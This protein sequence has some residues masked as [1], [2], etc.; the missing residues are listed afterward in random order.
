MSVTP[1]PID[2]TDSQDGTSDLVNDQSVKS[3]DG[4]SLP[5]KQP[6]TSSDP[7]LQVTLLPNGFK[8][9]L[10]PSSDS[11]EVFLPY[12]AGVNR[13]DGLL[14][15]MD[16]GYIPPVLLDFL[17]AKYPNKLDSYARQVDV[18]IKDLR[19]FNGSNCKNS[20]SN[21]RL[22]NECDAPSRIITLYPCNSTVI[23]LVRH[24]LIT[25]SQ[26]NLQNAY[27]EEVNTSSETTATITGNSSIYGLSSNNKMFKRLNSKISASSN[28]SS[29]SNQNKKDGN[30]NR[31]NAASSSSNANDED[32]FL[33]PS[34]E[35]FIESAV[36]LNTVPPLVLDPSPVVHLVER[37]LISVKSSVVSD[38]PA[39]CSKSRLLKKLRASKWQAS[40]TSTAFNVTAPSLSLASFLQEKSTKRS[41]CASRAT[42]KLPTFSIDDSTFPTSNNGSTDYIK[43]VIEDVTRISSHRIPPAAL[44]ANRNG[45]I[46]GSSLV[47]VEEYTMESEASSN[48]NLVSAGTGFQAMRPH[49]SGGGSTCISIFH[50]PVDDMFFGQLFI[51][52]SPVSTSSSR[53]CLFKLG[54]RDAA[55]RY[56][57][58]FKEILTEN[59]RKAV[60]ITRTGQQHLSS[61]PQPHQQSQ[62][63]FNQLSQQQQQQQQQQHYQQ[64]QHLQQ[65]QQFNQVAHQQAQPQFNTVAHQAQ[66]QHPQ[67]QQPQIHIH[68]QVT[69]TP[70]HLQQSHFA[71]QQQSQQQQQQH[72]Q[73]Q[74]LHQQQITLPLSSQVAPTHMQIHNA[75]TSSTATSTTQQILQPQVVT[76]SNVQVISANQGTKVLLP[77]VKTIQL[78]GN[79]IQMLP[80]P[81]QHHQPG[82]QPAIHTNQAQGQ[83][84]Q[85]T[86][87]QE[88]QLTQINAQQLRQIQGTHSFLVLPPP[89]SGPSQVNQSPSQ[90]FGSVQV[91]LWPQ[92][93]Q[94]QQQQQ[95]LQAI[96]AAVN[97]N[98]PNVSQAT[99]QLTQTHSNSANSSGQQPQQ[100]PQLIQIQPQTVAVASQAT[101]ATAVPAGNATAAAAV[102]GLVSPVSTVTNATES[103]NSVNS[104]G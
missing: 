61:H 17:A 27:D 69:Q 13:E 35:Q 66:P 25:L 85:A 33:D 11:P 81:S 5:S 53:S 31:K 14:E 101:A 42:K 91:I 2:Q 6:K 87:R 72:Q 94:Q 23:K 37:K 75:S 7:I 50:S 96:T 77:S 83:M 1:E 3:S 15:F 4:P 30:N 98:Q 46:E 58:Q 74:Q 100:L 22:T 47:K 62:Q 40:P 64:Q 59:G 68:Q 102:L 32:E 71:P 90:P 93:F 67:Q 52:R 45:S 63:Q 84:V 12:E 36:I 16:A 92:Q 73:Q 21:D 10:T 44:N 49:S 54:T 89:S 28:N 48:S 19:E 86:N 56:L 8:L 26:V 29:S 99:I 65:Q 97:A 39:A 103:T 79:Q 38:S 18:C 76:T 60:R 88:V 41:S 78:Q 9:K 95:G 34:H 43:K 24:K 51:D 80:S 20:P 104:N 82:Q 70:V 55:K 57:E